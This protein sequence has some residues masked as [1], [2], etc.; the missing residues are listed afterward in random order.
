MDDGQFMN[1]NITM[2]EI[3]SVRKVLKRKLMNIHH[4]RIAYPD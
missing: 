2:K 1:A 3:S 4:A